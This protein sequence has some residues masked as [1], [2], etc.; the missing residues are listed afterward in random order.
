VPV[1]WIYIGLPVLLMSAFQ[2]VSHA[3]GQTMGI[4]AFGFTGLACSA[5]FPLSISFGGEEFPRLASVMSGELIAFYQLGYGSPPLE[6][7]RCAELTRLPFSSM[8]SYGSLAAGLHGDTRLVS[9]S[10]KF[11]CVVHHAWPI[12]RI[13]MRLVSRA[14]FTGF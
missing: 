7:R 14:S 9:G 13:S 4:L 10:K 2:A 5:F 11:C 6:W 8:Y 3:G 1:R 12:Y